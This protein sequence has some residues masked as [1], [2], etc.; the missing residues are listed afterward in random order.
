[1]STQPAN[2][3]DQIRNNAFKMAMFVGDNRHYLV[4]RIL[5]RHFIQTASRCALP[6]D[7]MP[8]L[9]QELAAAVPTALQHAVPE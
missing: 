9:F 5:P 8:A 4:D 6:N 2:D 3:A 7:I 1:M